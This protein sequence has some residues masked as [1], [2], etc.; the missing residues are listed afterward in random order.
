MTESV[1]SRPSTDPA[2]PPARMSLFKK[3]ALGLSAVGP[4]LFL[5]GYNIGTGSVTTM[6][7]A[8]AQYGMTMLWAV[9][10][11][12]IFTYVLM[13][14][15][16]R[17]TLITGE[18]ALTSFR[19]HVPKIGTALALYVMIALIIGELLALMGVM[20]IVAELIQEGIRM[21]SSDGT[22]VVQTF[23]IISVIATLIFLMLWFG[24]YKLFEK[25]LTFFVLLMVFAFAVVFFMVAP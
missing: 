18:T 11:S 17:L 20:G 16:G 9:V 5:I 14:A 6:G 21:A 2:T 12:G 24:R 23:W 15:Y 3:I 13:V 7:M 8:G 19:K 4:G 25:V 1:K 22:L 10:L